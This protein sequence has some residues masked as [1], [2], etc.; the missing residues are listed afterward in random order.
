MR[1]TSLDIVIC[2]YNN[3]AL[4]DRTLAAI[5]RQKVSP[6]VRWRVV[7]VD[8]NCTDGTPEVV[9]RYA[10]EG[11]FDLR[12]VCETKQGLTPARVR[13]VKEGE[14][15]WIAFVDDDCLLA[16]NWIE[17]AAR[18][19]AEHPECGAF[20]G[21]IILEWEEQ[22]PPY[23]LNFPYAYAGASH[24][25]TAKRRDWLAGAGMVV[26]RTALEAC[27]WIDEQFLED[28]KGSR[29]ISG[30][31]VEI[32]MRIA[33]LYELWYNPACKLRHVIPARRTSREYLRRMVFGLGASRHNSNALKWRGSYAGWCFF[34]A[35]CS[36]GF[37]AM[38]VRQLALELAGRRAGVDVK[39]AFGPLVGWWTA[40]WGMFRMDASERR[41]LVG[42]AA[43]VPGG[44]A[45]E[46]PSL[47]VEEIDGA[48]TR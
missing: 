38:G 8:N 37:L 11:G 13:G 1:E 32:G 41:R 12:R 19:A 29:L 44:R 31:D 18:F 40:M 15:E 6:G 48:S 2:T 34:S 46:L 14:G 5:S 27:G 28:R 35:L 47:V 30:G 36:I 7:V 39:V 17:E 10:R 22:P 43:S 21:H 4:L 33:T 9:E 20:G 16:E 26:R 45:R 3:A 23:V 25:E 42:C 24:G